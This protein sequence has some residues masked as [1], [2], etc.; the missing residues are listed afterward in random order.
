MNFSC[1][2]YDYTDS[3]FKTNISFYSYLLYSLF[4]PY[5]KIGYVFPS[6]WGWGGS[7]NADF[8]CS[9]K[10]GVRP[11]LNILHSRSTLEWKGFMSFCCIILIA[12]IWP[13]ILIFRKLLMA[14]K[15]WK[16][17]SIYRIKKCLATIYVQLTVAVL[18]CNMIYHYEWWIIISIPSN[19]RHI[20]NFYRKMTSD[21]SEDVP[22]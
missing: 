15:N 11:F 2:W 22:R 5:N 14:Q 7:I 17:Y 12:G 6:F 18:C 1:F 3:D 21:M 20:E 13:Y 4:L 16:I 9:L 10:G 19:K 8:L